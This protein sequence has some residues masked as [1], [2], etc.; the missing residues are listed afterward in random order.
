MRTKQIIIAED[1]ALIVEDMK[2]RLES[3]GY[4]VSRT[5]SCAQEAVF[6]VQGL[7][8]DLVLMDIQLPGEMDGI[9][10]AEQIRPLHVPVVYVTGYCDGP[11]LE[12][13][14]LTEPYGYVLK[15]YQTRDLKAAI[16]IGLYKH[17]AERD[18]ER[19][20]QDAF[21]KVK[22]LT[23]LLSICAYCKKI[24]DEVG[25]WSEIENY[26]MRHTDASFTHGMCPDC[27]ERL[28]KQLDGLQETGGA[29]GS[30]VIG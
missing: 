10:A 17:R 1:D 27:F 11:V 14:K 24:K 3:L 8:P 20:L 23:G 19:L 12:R 28:K 25:Y 30:I 16:E 6:L 18:R 9:Q 22:A 5:T 21:A 2:A 15:P 29:V 13:A 4:E 26:I 7:K